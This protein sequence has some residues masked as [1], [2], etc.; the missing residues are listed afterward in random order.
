MCGACEG[1]ERIAGR[2]DYVT[3]SSSASPYDSASFL[4]PHECY[5]EGNAIPCPYCHPNLY[6]DI[7]RVTIRK[8]LPKPERA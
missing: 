5:M 8:D 7:R 6:G 2:V 3:W 1:A 4:T